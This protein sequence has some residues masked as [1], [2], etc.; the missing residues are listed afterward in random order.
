MLNNV[1]TFLHAH[2]RRVLMVAVIGTAIAGVFGVGVAKH[3]ALT[4][5]TIRQHNRSGHEPV[6]GG[7]GPADRPRDRGDR[8][9][10]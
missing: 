8:E 7:R 10:R 3:M 9:R 1:A 4:P 2:G 5:P 6:R